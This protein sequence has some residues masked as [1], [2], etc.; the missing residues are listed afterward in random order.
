VNGAVIET[1][2][3]PESQMAWVVHGSQGYLDAGFTTYGDSNKEITGYNGSLMPAFG[4]DLT[5][6]ELLSVVFYE[7][8]ELGGY[9]DELELA[10]TVWAMVESGEL[11][12]PEHWD[13]G[14]E[15]DFADQIGE[16]LAE[17]RLLLG[18]DS[19]VASG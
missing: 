15:G 5:A 3:E 17:A 19:I 9:E 14:P 1:F 2:V 18:G 6:A 7:R 10:E 12:L 4:A 16:S 13:E 8:I 11:V